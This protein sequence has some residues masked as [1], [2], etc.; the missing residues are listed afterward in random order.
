MTASPRPTEPEVIW[1]PQPGPQTLLLACPIEDVFYGG[2]RGGGKTDGLLGDFLAQAGEYGQGARG[3]LFRRSFPELE[4]V[5]RRANEILIPLGWTYVAQSH[6]FTAPN[7]ATLRLRF[8]ERDSDADHYQ[9]HQYSWMGFD[10]VQ[11]WLDPSPLNK[12]WGSLRSPHGVP[13]VRR[14][15]G[16]PPAPAW[17]KERYIDRAPPLTPFRY[18]PLP[19]LRPDLSVEAVFI[20]AKL[21]DNPLLMQKDPGYEGRLAAVGGPRLYEAW[22]HGRWDVMIGQV[23]EEWRGDL[24]IIE[25]SW[26][27]PRFWR[28]AGGC[29]WGY[30]NPGWFGLFASGPDGEQVCVEEVYFRQQ[31]A[32]DVGYGVGVLC[33]GY[34]QVEYIA[35]DEQ[36]WYQTGVSA[37]NL[38]E[39]FQKGLVDAWGGDIE[40][41]PKLIPAT[42]GRGSRAAKLAVMHRY[43]KWTPSPK[44][45]TVPP[46]GQPKLKFK[47]RCVAAIRT[48]PAL[49]YDPHKPED[50][51]TDAEDHAYDGVSAYLMSRP[52]LAERPPKPLVPDQHPGVDRQG[53]KRRQWERALREMAEGREG[54]GYRVPRHLVPTDE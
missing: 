51:D 2:A 36:M 9:G 43:L 32:Y 46:W 50:V 25:D 16:N 42:H 31:T 8:L 27:P 24:H 37:P 26:A 14:L 7:G 3:I 45:D 33:R 19:D 34:E 41:V 44:G 53:R 22:R 49:P 11:Q 17:L 5:I 52:A 47:R 13:C 10:E 48:I 29:D 38:A 12:L 21:E 1:S 28:F 4:E 23:F 30:R 6:T 35:G 15:T 40:R 20:P 39:E 18:Q 54:E